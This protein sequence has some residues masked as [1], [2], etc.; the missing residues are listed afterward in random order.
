MTAMLDTLQVVL[1]QGFR[2]LTVNEI[3]YSGN[4]PEILYHDG[5]ASDPTRLRQ[6]YFYLP[7]DDHYHVYVI[8]L[9]KPDLD[10]TQ[11][12][13][14]DKLCASIASQSMNERAT[15]SVGGSC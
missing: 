8:T 9:A 3:V 7:H 10:L 12:P 13:L 14:T 2:V 6:L 1:S 5:M 4:T 11:D 15:V